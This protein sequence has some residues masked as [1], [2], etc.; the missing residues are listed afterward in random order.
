MRSSKAASLATTVAA[1][2]ML[3]GS[4]GALC[5]QQ[6][7]DD[8]RMRA[9]DDYGETSRRPSIVPG[10]RIA[11]LGQDGTYIILRDNTVWEVYLPDRTSTVGWRE[12]DFLIVKEAPVGHGNYTFELI[13]GR[14]EEKAV[15][16][17]EGNTG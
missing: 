13:N 10:E 4:A 1:I 17:F 12:G 14:T 5:A 11:H 6:S 15:V 8:G 9:P 16:R 7:N 3:L 2:A